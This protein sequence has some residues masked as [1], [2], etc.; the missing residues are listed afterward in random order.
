MECPSWSVHQQVQSSAIASLGFDPTVMELDHQQYID[1]QLDGTTER[2]MIDDCIRRTPGIPLVIK[3]SWQFPEREDEGKMLQKATKKGVINVARYYSHATVRIG[4]NDDDIQGNVRKGLDVTKASNYGQERPARSSQLRIS[5]TGSKRSAS[6]VGAPL[7]LGKRSR[8]GSV[9]PTKPGGQPLPNRVHRRIILRDYGKPIYKA[10]SR[11]ALLKALEGCIQGHKS[12]L[13]KTG[14]LHRDISINNLMINEDN[15]NPSWASFLID[16]DLAIKMDRLQAS[17]AKEKTGTRAFMAIGVLSGG[18]HSYMDD[19]ESFY[20]VLLWVCIHYDGKGHGRDVPGFDR[21]N[22]IDTEALIQ[23]K[24][25]TL[26]KRVFDNTVST[27]FT[28]HYQPLISWVSKLRDVVF[29]NGESWETE[30]DELYKEMID[31]LCEAQA[32]PL[33]AAAN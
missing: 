10:S 30:H 7:P 17:G 9:S 14:F 13:S 27:H 21:W 20:W 8:S 16:L 24:Q 12:L 28:P 22:T 29:P 4:D 2:L 11:V 1:I 23:Q 25:G 15:E 19:L 31:I 3:D 18:R 26:S 33:V 5:S 6:Q 32:D